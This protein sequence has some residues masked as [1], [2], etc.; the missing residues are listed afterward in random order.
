MLCDYENLFENFINN[1]H[2][3]KSYRAVK[4]QILGIRQKCRTTQIA[5]K[6]R[7]SHNQDQLI[8]A[9]EQIE[10]LRIC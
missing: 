10:D 3:D 4:L 9:R 6:N 1:H 5:M 7:S 8:L 2:M